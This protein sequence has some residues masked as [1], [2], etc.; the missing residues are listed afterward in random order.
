MSV[1]EHV[2]T[3][4]AWDAIAS[5]YDELVTPTANWKVAEAALDRVDVGRG[6]HLLDVACGSGALSLP[7]ARRGAQVLGVDFAPTMITCLEGRA[8]AEGLSNLQG[9][10]MDAHDL[11]LDDDIFDVAASQFGVMLLPDQPRA[12][13]EMVRVTKPGGKVL[14]V[15]YRPPEEVEFLTFFL[16]AVQ[17]VVPGFEGPPPDEPM[18][19]FQAADP[20][21]LR[22]RMQAAGL[23]DVT[24]EGAVEPL[25]ARSGA[26]LWN[27]LVS[28]NPI[29][30]AL[31]AGLD[32][33]QRGQV[34][35]LLHEMLRERGDGRLP[36]TLTSGINLAVGA[37]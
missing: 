21:V 29:P 13:R 7:A 8:R 30:G 35:Q 28:S 16:G 31:T 22:R 11:D 3:S 18:L 25:M 24:V 20:E 9:R 4:D 17:A 2:V 14:I 12:L 26:H 15:S 1:M 36:A 19:P 37:T 10:V 34:R 23:R 6:A 27:W 5:D 33:H 32:D